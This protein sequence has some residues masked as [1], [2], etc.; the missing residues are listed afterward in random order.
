MDAMSDLEI[1]PLSAAMIDQLP[2][3]DGPLVVR[4]SKF[5]SI[6]LRSS[7]SQALK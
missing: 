4:L 7:P 3:D 5:G 6:C 2:E 1:H